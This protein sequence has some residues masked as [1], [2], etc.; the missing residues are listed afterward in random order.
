MLYSKLAVQCS[1]HN[2]P[3][4]YQF[5]ESNLYIQAPVNDITLTIEIVTVSLIS[6]PFP[7]L[8]HKW[9]QPMPWWRPWRQSQPLSIVSLLLILSP[10]LVSMKPVRSELNLTP[11]LK[12][13]AA[14][15][16]GKEACHR[17]QSRIRLYLKQ[18]N[19]TIYIFSTT[20]E[21]YKECHLWPFQ[22][23]FFSPHFFCSLLD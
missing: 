17:I 20:W 12:A 19:Y 14:Q 10:I 22:K 1:L 11:L 15:G 5:L 4:I 2:C 16:L 6:C 8:I 7:A 13:K 23:L 21:I 3:V 18:T 9:N